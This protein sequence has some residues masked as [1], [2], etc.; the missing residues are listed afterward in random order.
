MIRI[1]SL[2]VLVATLVT[3]MTSAFAQSDMLGV[4]GPITF[5]GQDYNLR[6]TS[7]P[8]KTYVKQEYVPAGQSPET[9]TDMILVEAVSGDITPMQA[10]ATQVKSLEARKAN[11]PVINYQV[12]ENEG[13]G[14]VM[15]DFV[16]SDLK[17][18]PIIVEWNA[19]RY[20][21]LADGNGVALFAVSRRGYGDE[22]ARAFLG[23][24][25]ETRA[26]VIKEVVTYSVPA[27]SIAP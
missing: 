11:D 14:E 20:M 23:S 7:R 9:Y 4:P 2:A 26:Q 8:S 24:L 3:A 13:A 18:D 1:R 12:I 25:S 16:V 10:A 27:V 17:A 6:W 21:R 15:L 22:T 19:Y 5:L